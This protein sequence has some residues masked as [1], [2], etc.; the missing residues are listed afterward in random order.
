MKI[1]GK[2]NDGGHNVTRW[3]ALHKP[4]D[5]NSINWYQKTKLVRRLQLRIAKAY[6]EGRY[7]RATALQ[8]L[9]TGSLSA[10]VLAVKRVV[11][12]KGGKTPGVDNVIWKTAGQKWQ[13]ALALKRQ[14]Y[15]PQPLKRIYI[16]K[17]TGKLRPLSIPAMHCRAMQALHL[18]ALE[19]IA[20]MMVDKNA[21]GFRPL[22]STVDAIEQCFIVLASRNRAS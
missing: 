1:N 6:R 7:N 13:A 10:K 11:E 21:Y 3:C 4:G 8:R 12:N 14:G 16:P 18:Q 15:K 17:R 5:W 2:A 20:E 9:L 22:R 19:P